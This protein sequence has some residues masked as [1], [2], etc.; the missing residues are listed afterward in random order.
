MTALHWAA[1]NED[2]QTCDLLLKNGAKLLL[3]SN[4]ITA[5]DIAGYCE[6]EKVF[7]VFLEFV[8]A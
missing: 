2:D 4:L 7:N 8:I 6:C 1:F 3:N 5:V